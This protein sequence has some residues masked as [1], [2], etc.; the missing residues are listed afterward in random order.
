MTYTKIK[1]LKVGE[2]ISQIFLVAEVEPGTTKKN[3]VYGK[4]ILTDAESQFR[5]NVWDFNPRDYPEIQSG[6]FVSMTV[7]VDEFK[8]EKNGK[9]NMTPMP[10]DPPTDTEP[11]CDARGP[12]DVEIEAYWKGLM[13]YKDDVEDTYIKA[14]LDTIFTN[15]KTIDLF[16]KAP[17]SSSNRG[18]YKGGLVEH[19]LKVMK[20]ADFLMTSQSMAHNAAPINRDV[21][22]AGVLTHDLG[23]MYAYHVDHT[24]AHTTGS[25]RLLGHLVPSYGLSVQAFI[26]TES[27]IRKE[28]PQH[29]KDHI[30]HC[31]L[32]H[33][34][35]LEYGSP[36]TPMSIEAMIVH[37]AD[38]AD[39]SISN[40]AEP[41]VDKRAEA[42]KDNMI[43][44]SRFYNSNNIYIDPNGQQ[45]IRNS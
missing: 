7:E 16:K 31:I 36:V 20:N 34:G 40:F 25:G 5:V 26:A 39:C 42:N 27:A 8:G 4:F 37:Q 29:I 19:V 30:H 6:S 28:I 41:I 11:Y 12:E 33:H 22:I 23:K 10:V 2:T 35:R 32:A 44:G 17:A 14:Y 24:G 21:V 13:K 43:K 3:T 9:C 15:P 18:A 45:P 38:I 1:D